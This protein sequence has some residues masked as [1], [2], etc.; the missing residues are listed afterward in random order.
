[1]TINALKARLA[2]VNGRI[3][4][5]ETRFDRQPGSVRLLAA[6]KKQSLPL[7]RQ[8]LQLGVNNFGENYAK[9]AQE[10]I[11][12]LGDEAI[13]WHFIGHLQA[14]K[15]RFIS[16]HCHWVH[17]VSRLKIA[18]RLNNQRPA[19]LDPLN[20]CLQ[21]NIGEEASKDG[22]PLAEVKALATAISPLS[23]LRL[24]GLM[25]IPPPTTDFD[26]QTAYAQQLQACYQQLRA[27][28]FPVDTLSMGMSNDLEAAIAA[29]STWVRIGSA[30]C[31]PRD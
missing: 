14:N 1:M 15:T 23:R 4:A 26:Q 25:M 6:T 27:D 22:V 18:E 2:A 13:I 19:H 8:L 30:L 20:I 9:E 31:G 10:K 16:E 7:M 17:S 12:A 29:G 5:A 24:R 28:G 21:V 3:A 11:I